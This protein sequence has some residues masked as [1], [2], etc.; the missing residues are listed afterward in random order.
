MARNALGQAMRLVRGELAAF[1]QPEK[2]CEFA[3]WVSRADLSSEIKGG[4]LMAGTIDGR[5]EANFC[6]GG[7]RPMLDPR[8]DGAGRTMHA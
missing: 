3:Y 7:P 1:F 4:S 8:L 2:A 5:S 6:A